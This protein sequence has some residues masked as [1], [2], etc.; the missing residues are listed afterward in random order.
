VS[1]SS[2]RERSQANTQ[3][4]TFPVMHATVLPSLLRESERFSRTPEHARNDTPGILVDRLGVIWVRQDM[5]HACTEARAAVPPH[6]GYAP[7]H[8]RRPRRSRGHPVRPHDAWATSAPCAPPTCSA[9]RHTERRRT[10]A[11]AKPGATGLRAEPLHYSAIVA[12]IG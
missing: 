12:E 10:C 11:F 5:R 4:S 7:P 6:A 8:G 9:S 3:Y 2:H 1:R